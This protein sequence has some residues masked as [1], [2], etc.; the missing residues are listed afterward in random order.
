[1]S[2]STSPPVGEPRGDRPLERF[3]VILEPE[4]TVAAAARTAQ[5][6]ALDLDRLPDRDNVRLL[7]D[8]DQLARLQAEGLTIRVQRSVPVQPL[9]P[10]LIA[11]DEDVADWLAT[12][13]G[14]PGHPAGGPT[15]G[16][17]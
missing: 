1:M 14:N 15:E 4:P 10:A 8:A 12:R 3:E 13:L 5:I 6:S 11:A 16:A 2:D 9:D 17:R 7:V